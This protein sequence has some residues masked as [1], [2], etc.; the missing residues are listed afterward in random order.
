MT[1]PMVSR[2]RRLSRS[3]SW[4]SRQSPPEA[5]D[6]LGGNFTAS[7]TDYETVHLHILAMADLLSSRI[8]RQF[9]ARFH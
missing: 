7:V 3:P 5:S 6:E 1:F 2:R 4:F 8:M 9:P